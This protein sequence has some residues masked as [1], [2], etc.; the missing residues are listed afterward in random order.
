MLT[1]HVI[2]FH[3]VGIVILTFFVYKYLNQWNRS[4]SIQIK[5]IIGMIFAAM[6]MFIAGMTE[7]IRQKYCLPSISIFERK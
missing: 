5:L 6:A 2:L 3:L 1:I 4:I 7:I